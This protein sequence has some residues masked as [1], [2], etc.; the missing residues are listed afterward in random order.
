M[1][2]SRIK[3]AGFKSFVDPTT[4]YLPS[5]LVGI[6]GPN[7]CGKSNVIDAVRW[8]MGEMS[9]KHLRGDSMA[10]VIFNGSASR[11][12]VGSASIEL[13][14]D[15]ADGSI[16]GQYAQYAEI[17]LRRT[18]SRDGTSTYFLNNTRCRRKDITDLFLGTGLGSR[19]YAIIEQ[20]MV[21]RLVEAKP[22]EMRTYIEEAA[23]ISRYKERRRETESR[24]Q[25]TRDNLARL[26]D[27]RE[28]ISKQLDNLQRQAKAAERYKE[29]KARERRLEAELLA[30]RLSEIERGLEH[31]RLDLARRET[32]LEAAIAAQRRIEAEIVASRERQIAA[33]DAFNLVQA[34][35]YAVQSEISRLEQEIAHTREIRERQ[36]ADLTQARE[37]ATALSAEIGR[38]QLQVQD[39]TSAL[40][41]LQPALIEARRAEES[42]AVSLQRAEEALE[43]WQNSWHEFNLGVKELQQASQIEH[44][45]VE[46]LTAQLAQLHRQQQSLENDHKQILRSDLDA[47]LNAQAE[48]ER[49][50]GQQ[51]QVL[52]DRLD[53]INREMESLGRQ[54]QE[55]GRDLELATAAVSSR[56]GELGALRAIQQAAL[57]SEDS[58]LADWLT[59]EKLADRP[60]LAE[61]LR[62]D[63][64]WVLAVE[65]VLGDFLQAVCVKG[66]AHHLTGIPDT[67]FTLLENESPAEIADSRSLLA[68][69]AEPGYATRL[70]ANVMVA[71]TLSEA[72]RLQREVGS[73]QSV[74]TPD[75]I[76]LGAGWVRVNR[77][78]RSAAG[79][80][81]REQQIREI[82]VAIATEEARISEIE[83]QRA[84]ARR[85]LAFLGESRVQGTQE[86]NAANRDHAEALAVLE[87]LRQESGRARERR[88]LLDRDLAQV[89][90]EGA[91]LV[92]S[93]AEAKARAGVAETELHALAARKTELQRQQDSCLA[94]Y[95]EAR[96][97]AERKRDA[98]LRL[99]VEV[100]NKRV[101]KE[102]AAC[103]LERLRA[104]EQQ[105][106]EMA[107]Q[108]ENEIAAAEPAAA[109]LHAQLSQHLE[110][111]ID[112]DRLLAGRRAELELVESGLRG[113]EG[114]RSSAEKT[115]IAAREAA[116]GLRMQVREAEVRHEAVMESFAATGTAL[117]LVRQEM[118]ADAEAAGWATA[119]DDVR[120]KIDRL[121][122]INLAAIEQ[123]SEQSDRKKYLDAQNDDLNA[124]LETLEQAIRKI[125]RETR[126]RFQ[127]TFENI[128]QGLKRIFPRL[129]GG[130]HAYLSLE[131]EDIL[132]AG[133]TVMARPPGKRNSHIHL[134]SGG[135]KALTAVALIFSIFELNPAP[136]CLL[137]EVDAPLDEANVGRFC[138][139]V[140]EMAQR[141]QFVVITHN[142]TTME[143]TSQLTGVTMNEPGVSRLVSVD[144]DAAVQLAAS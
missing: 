90:A 66:F 91:R 101:S 14:F 114:Q 131:G 68:H 24:I 22:E 94:A 45:R 129:F 6:V 53:A 76:W 78:R 13:F 100:E 95:N 75:G 18:I 47:R 105:V 11:K 92:A 62:V 74:I 141:V 55:L 39:L 137:D 38:D 126:A 72:V 84:D 117:D 144:L 88:D 7:G 3:L 139:I 67:R 25:H 107:G 69:V 59:R 2:L 128:N 71:D 32:E 60:R 135:E 125:D 20:G 119:L 70:L 9:A 37:R 109:A 83:Q 28:E 16:G 87:N 26:N 36:Q 17:S 110:R 133:V 40:G 41:Q 5:N 10:D 33:T 54:E 19:S 42:A 64:K 89:T 132:L 108:L 106:A 35:H 120:R 81:T 122:P 4:F 130:G 49:T 121:G 142:K 112:V 61:Q 143:M 44:T 118:P 57:G 124:A 34:D 30:M 73:H 21:S 116:E 86:F 82:V 63:G 43:Q 51:A 31:A 98:V 127:E 85:R 23:G 52:Q 97:D 58:A 29:L 96:E 77:G 46:H 104:Q 102:S 48:L 65:T 111:Q 80:L 140:R 138:D 8:V 15:N 99:N 56:K 79:L 50:S 27:L 103:S 136:F 113:S 115:V 93:V 1:R 12:P 123:F 134:L